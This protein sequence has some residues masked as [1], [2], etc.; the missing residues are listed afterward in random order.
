MAR[1]MYRTTLN[2]PPQ[3]AFGRLV[4]YFRSR[5]YAPS[6]YRGE[7]IWKEGI[8]M[9]TAM[10][11]IKISLLPGD[12]FQI[13]GWVMSGL[14]KAAIPAE[15]NLSG[16]LGVIPKK[17]VQS[18]ISGMLPIISSDPNIL[19]NPAGFVKS[20]ANDSFPDAPAYWPEGI[21]QAAPA[22]MPVQG[23]VQPMAPP[24]APMQT[25]PPRGGAPI[26]SARE[27]GFTFC[28]KCGNRV[29]VAPDWQKNF[30]YCNQ[31]G[32]QLSI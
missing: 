3:E 6:D 10:H 32:E 11:Y 7:M 19:S 4:G 8:G 26:Q 23:Q 30:I 27:R 21:P 20:H 17:Q 31:C 15:M 1:S 29:T 24:P 14:G 18:V 16:A 25:Q 12:V 13:S 5:G 22:S 9:L 28:T 2:C